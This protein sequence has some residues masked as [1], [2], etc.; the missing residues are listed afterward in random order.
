MSDRHVVMS[1]ADPLR[2]GWRPRSASS[3]RWRR[4]AAA[5]GSRTLPSYGHG[6]ALWRQS[7]FLAKGAGQDARYLAA[8]LTGSFAFNR[9]RANARDPRRS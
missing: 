6:A 4:P 3:S 2:S 7:I 1:T 9:A 8:E 5:S